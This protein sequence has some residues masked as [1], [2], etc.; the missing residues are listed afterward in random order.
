[1]TL[2]LV[3]V[4]SV[5]G[6]TLATVIGVN[7]RLTAQTTERGQSVYIAEA[8]LETALAM[9][10]AATSDDV[11][12][13]FGDLDN[14]PCQVK[15]SADGSTAVDQQFVVTIRYGIEDPAA[16]AGDLSWLTAPQGSPSAPTGFGPIPCMTGSGPTSQPMYALVE[17]A[18]A[19]GGVGARTLLAVYNFDLDGARVVDGGGLIKIYDALSLCLRADDDVEG[20]L[21]RYTDDC[22]RSDP[23]ESKLL[24]WTYDTDYKIR[25][26][27]ATPLDDP[28]TGEIESRV[29]GLCI[30]GP[31]TAPTTYE[32]VTTTQWSWEY[33]F[34]Q[35]K[36]GTTWTSATGT[37]PLTDAPLAYPTPVSHVYQTSPTRTHDYS[38]QSGTPVNGTPGTPTVT[39]TGTGY[40]QVVKTVTKTT[41]TGLTYRGNNVNFTPTYL[42][43]V[44]TD[45]KRFIAHGGVF[46]KDGTPSLDAGAIPVAMLVNCSTW[47]AVDGTGNLIGSATYN[48]IRWGWND[49]AGWKN[50]TGNCLY[51]GH[52]ASTTTR[53]GDTLSILNACSGQDQASWAAFAPEPKVGAGNASKELNQLVNFQEFGRCA[54]VTSQSITSTFMITYPCKQDPVNPTGFSWNHKWYYTDPVD[55]VDTGVTKITVKPTSTTTYCLV[56]P[57]AANGT[58]TFSNNTTTCNS[59]AAQW[60]RTTWTGRYASSFTFVSKLN[61]LCLGTD[62]ANNYNGW[63]K[64]TVQGCS[65]QANQKWNAPADMPSEGLGD[66]QEIPAGS[67]AP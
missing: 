26:A 44:Q 23:E 47:T 4:L 55:P 34:P 46:T 63:S 48:D 22:D 39:T 17:S 32:E 8:G 40:A 7:A 38:Y 30:A 15:G 33:S 45:T 49:N 13:G 11:G 65:G 42:R 59:A 25:L 9:F 58:V 54:D 62:P 31:V 21:V 6:V 43:L 53:N 52:P 19:A 29:G 10:R 20:S 37:T 12:A 51:S 2:M 60:T 35:V 16:H 66:Y 28:L 61:G 41:V 5:A 1:M 24:G 3:L 27:S 64:I 56:A 14:L 50:V 57:S 18:A 36:S 67:A